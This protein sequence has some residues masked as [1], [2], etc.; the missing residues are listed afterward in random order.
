MED[1]FDIIV[2]GGGHA[3]AEAALIAARM[4]VNTLLVTSLLDAIARM[5]CNPSI[6][7]LAKSHL[8]FE[9]DALGGEMGFNA[10]LT[11]LQEKTLNT[12]RGPAVQATRAQCDK[13]EYTLRMQ[14]II[15]S[16]PH[17]TVIEDGVVNIRTQE[18][19][20][21]D[22]KHHVRV[23]GVDTEQHGFIAASRVILTTGTSLRGRIF[24]GKEAT[25]SGGDGRPAVDRLSESLQ[26]LGFTLIR[27]KTG[28]PPRLTADSIDYSKTTIQPGEESPY[29]FSLRTR[30]FFASHVGEFAGERAEN[31]VA[32]SISTPEK[33]ATSCCG[34]E[35]PP[36]HDSIKS[37]S[38]ASSRGTEHCPRP[39]HN[40]HLSTTSSLNGESQCHPANHLVPTWKQVLCGN[41]HDKT[42]R[43]ST[44][45]HELLTNYSPIQVG[46]TSTHKQGAFQTNVELGNNIPIQ[47]PRPSVS[48]RMSVQVPS[49]YI[50]EAARARSTVTAKEN[51]VHDIQADIQD[52]RSD[53]QSVAGREDIPEESD[54]CRKVTGNTHLIPPIRTPTVPANESPLQ[55]ETSV[56]L[57]RTST[58]LD[59]SLTPP[60]KSTA[61]MQP[62]GER[63]EVRATGFVSTWK[64]EQA[65]VDH[66]APWS[67]NSQ[68]KNCYA[69]HT[70]PQSHEIIRT[71]LKDSALYGGAI[72]GTGVRYCPSIED[73]IVR[74]THA[75]SHHVILEP[76]DRAGTIIYPNGLSNS[77]PREVQEQLV[78][79]IPGL[80]HAT[81]LAY[82]YAIEYDGI[83]AR[84]LLHTLESKRIGGLYFAGQVNGTTGY[85]EAAAQGIMAGINAAF[86][87]RG[88]EP[89]VFSRQDAY[90]G[91]LIDDL[92][93]KGTDEPYRM[94]TSRA[95]RRL[96]L[97]QDN[98]RY[99]LMDAADRIGV[100][101]LEIREQTHTILSAL[102]QI[103]TGSLHL[104]KINGKSLTDHLNSCRSLE[105]VHAFAWQHLDL[106]PFP[107]HEAGPIIEQLWIRHHYA[108]YIRQEEIAAARAKKDETIRIPAWLDYDACTAVRFESREKLK[109][110]RP[111]TLA[112]AARIPGVNPAD[113]AVL[114]I[115]IKRGHV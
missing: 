104:E 49:R 68:R 54:E 51:L 33:V 96:I 91:V 112:Q 102:T 65:L 87:V 16:Q 17:L 30:H 12:S 36:S 50:D 63:K 110:Y 53:I 14:R 86:A 18:R 70:T 115:I 77:L 90:I 88:E 46:S 39:S 114:A 85:E 2:V 64:H 95:E 108:G 26:K 7:G 6:G 43:V 73:K 15:A 62:S 56:L 76:E 11:S 94:F 98:A 78:H 1:K 13:S 93:T 20:A 107:P 19:S 83:D 35:E 48:E 42:D 113:I 38:D 106:F 27:L 97:R 28:T 45:K 74:F 101:P 10:D 47:Q 22:D 89:L 61:E 29:F 59:P 34:D 52:I 37:E 80:E 71:H 4:G 8:V 9:L 40:D 25:P 69:T 66:F 81:F 99:R 67:V 100:L 21:E 3:G 31:H 41:T 23:I 57:S 82:A 109:K 79:S 111:E 5:P 103:E 72:E 55:E 58:L 60:S 75:T 32:A 24:I 84:E 44:W 92:V 105:E